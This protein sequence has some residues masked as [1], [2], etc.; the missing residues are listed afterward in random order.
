MINKKLIEEAIE[1]I[2]VLNLTAVEDYIE[3][4]ITG[5]DF[6]NAASENFEL[7]QAKLIAATTHKMNL[8]GVD[9][10]V[11]PPATRE[12]ELRH[13]GYTES[14]DFLKAALDAEPDSDGRNDPEKALAART[15]VNLS[16]ANDMVKKADEIAAR[17]KDD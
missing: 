15:A 14:A 1:S 11:T 4:I 10:S 2:K 17:N 8:Q 13:E 5:K 6:N 16:I 7:A 12:V 9:E 3:G